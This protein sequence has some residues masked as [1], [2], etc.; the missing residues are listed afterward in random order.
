MRYLS[1]LFVLFVM[2]VSWSFIKAPLDIP[3]TTHI[4]IQDDIK[5]H[6]TDTMQKLLPDVKDFKFDRFWT[7]NLDKNKVKAVFEFSFEN[8]AE[9][10]NPARYGIKGHAILNFD[11]EKEAWNVEGPYFANDQIQFKD[12][13][14]IR[15][16]AAD[17][18]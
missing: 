6:I 4:D 18:E 14:I 8:A 1:L 13:M 16:G 11:E 5:L 10:V 3:E 7:Q 9:L 17:G 12:G 2:Y 15:P